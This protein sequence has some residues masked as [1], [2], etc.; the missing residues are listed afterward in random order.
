MI[1]V[2]DNYDSFAYNLVQRLGEL[3]WESLV[4]RNDEITLAEI[5]VLAPSHIVISPGPCTPL[6]A[7]I[8]NETVLHFGGKIPILGVCL[9]HQCIGYVY[10]GIVD[11][12]LVPVHGKASLV[13]HDNEVLYRDIQNP[14]IAGRYHSLVVKPEGFPSCLK[15]TA[16]TEEGEI[17]GIRHKEYVVEGTQIHPESI[18][19][20]VGYDLLTNFLRFTTPVWPEAANHISPPLE[21]GD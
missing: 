7:G 12:A 14:F 2:I 20:D 3:G 18:L 1:L 16:R 21:G 13:Y 19:T 9:G 6:E 11:R 8:S 4:Y 10:G 5:E 17:M 15:I